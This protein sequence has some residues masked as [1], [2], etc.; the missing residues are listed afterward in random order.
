MNRSINI[1]DD[2]AKAPLG[3]LHMRLA[4]L[5]AMVVF[6]DGFNTSSASYVIQY[7]RIPWKLSPSEAGFLVSSGLIGFMFGAITQGKI[8]DR[9]GRKVTL[10]GAMWIAGAFSLLTAFLAQT[11]TIFCL[12]RFLAGLG[13]GAL[14]PL[15]ITYMNE[16]TPERLLNGF[17][18][19]GWLLGFA[20]GGVA[21]SAS[22]VWLTP[23]YGWQI[24]NYLGS[25]VILLALVCQFSLPESIKFSAMR[26]D[27]AAVVRT[28]SSLIP[29]SRDRYRADAVFIFPESTENAG[30]VHILLSGKMRRNSLLIWSCAFCVLFAIY[31]LIG[32]IPAVMIQRGESFATSFIDGALV[33]AAGFMGTL[34]CGILADRWLGCRRSMII[35][36]IAGG[37]SS[38]LL[39]LFNNHWLNVFCVSCAGFFILG[40]QG[41]LN[42]YTA[43][44]SETEVRAT[45]VGMMLGVGRMGAI[46]GP[47]ALGWLQEMSRRPDAL[48]LVIA[49]ASIGGAVMISFVRPIVRR[50]GVTVL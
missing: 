7:V 38:V 1:C 34:V 25:L 19:W 16:F 45:A 17:S 49:A 39:A 24:L 12:L 8:S 14:L 2:I 4:S 31:G 26:G 32:W 20:G 47:Y 22:A 27:R 28:L 43:N 44:I 46:T 41:V 11:F 35:W 10:L 37:I 3:W 33:Q 9:W 15:G 13:L 29:S 36:W 50:D 23:Q 40:A 18:I 48:F 30:N 21:A 42:N 5:I 6:F